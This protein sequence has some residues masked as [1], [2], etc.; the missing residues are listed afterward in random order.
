MFFLILIVIFIYFFQNPIFSYQKEED[1]TFITINTIE[2]ISHLDDS[3]VQFIKNS[4][5]QSLK[6]LDC[7]DISKIY[8]Y[9]I[10]DNEDFYYIM[11]KSSLDHTTLLSLNYELQNYSINDFKKNSNIY[12]F[13]CRGFFTKNP[14]QSQKGYLIKIV[15]KDKEKSLYFYPN[16]KKYTLF[17]RNFD[18]NMDNFKIE[19]TKKYNNDVEYIF[20]LK[21]VSYELSS[22]F[23]LRFNPFKKKQEFHKGIDIKVPSNT[24]LY[25][26]MDG[27]IVFVGNKKGYGK[28]IVIRKKEEIFL[29]AHLSEILVKVNDSITKGQIIG[30]TGNTGFSTGPHLHLEYKKNFKN[31]DPL[32]IFS[33][34]FK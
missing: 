12:L 6:E 24:S 13:H 17:H 31:V 25:A 23:G 19:H 20:P 9:T 2:N 33:D 8:E 7:K 11:G 34:F 4:I 29:F 10:K 27:K 14:I 5:K 3:K 28:T 26:P 1:L 30:K 18:S 15:L 16:L 32:T 22:K 21:D